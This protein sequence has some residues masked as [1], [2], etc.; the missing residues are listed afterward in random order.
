VWFRFQV[1]LSHNLRSARHSCMLNCWCNWQDGKTLYDELELIEGMKFDR[2]YISPYFINTTK[3]QHS[4]FLVY[5][6]VICCIIVIPAQKYPESN[7]KVCAY[8]ENHGMLKSWKQ[9]LKLAQLAGKLQ[10][11][12]LVCGSDSWPKWHHFCCRCSQKF[13]MYCSC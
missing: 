10:N 3:G 6:I 9:G 12:Q 7:P 1:K 13:G 4:K 5:F 2:G 11:Y 8:C